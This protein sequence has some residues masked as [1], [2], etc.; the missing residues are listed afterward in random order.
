MPWV[1]IWTSKLKCAYVWTTPVKC[2][3]VWTTKVR[4]MGVACLCLY[5]VWGG[6]S[7]WAWTCSWCCFW[8]WGWAW[9]VREISNACFTPW[10]YNITVWEWGWKCSFVSV[11]WCWCWCPSCIS[12]NWI[13]YC[14]CG[15]GC[16]AWITCCSW[17]SRKQQ[18]T[19]ASWWSGGWGLC[20]RSWGSHI[21][22]WCGHGWWC[23]QTCSSWMRYGWGGWWAW[24]AGKSVSDTS[25]KP[26][27]WIWVNTTFFW[28]SMCIA[29]GWWGGNTNSCTPNCSWNG[30]SCVSWTYWWWRW[31]GCNC[32]WC[33]ATCYWWGWWW[34]WRSTSAAICPWGAGYQWIVGIRYPAS[35]NYNITWGTKYSCTIGGTT[36]CIHC[37]TS[38]GTLTVS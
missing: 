23:W 7:W 11:D 34:S 25:A 31:S 16:G 32:C 15:W 10:T 22:C 20:G 8:W 5:L 21:W 19:W 35:C 6:G 4:P 2:I 38:N 28:A 36:Y 12:W 17:Y 30:S 33:P 27:W 14:V 37:F 3:Y 24:A 13:N 1:Y 9:W 26:V 18:L 29:G